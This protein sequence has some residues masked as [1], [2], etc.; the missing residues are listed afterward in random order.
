MR[1]KRE[2]RRR[3]N[4]GLRQLTPTHKAQDECCYLLACVLSVRVCEFAV[5]CGEE[6]IIFCLASACEEIIFYFLKFCYSDTRAN[7][8]RGLVVLRSCFANPTV[9]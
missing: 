4:G 1:R 2:E 5:C 6:K 3:K 7:N 8:G 9:S